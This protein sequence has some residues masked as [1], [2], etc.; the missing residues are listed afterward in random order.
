MNTCPARRT[1]PG[2]FKYGIRKN[3]K[4]KRNPVDAAAYTAIRGRKS[5]PDPMNRLS[6]PV[7]ERRA[8]R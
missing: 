5:F 4:E 2:K 6:N 7:R 3:R 8:K 1:N